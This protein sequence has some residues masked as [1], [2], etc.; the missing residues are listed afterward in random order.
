MDSLIWTE[1]YRPRSFKEFVGQKEIVK[2]VK[3]M[4]EQKNLNHLLLAGPAGCGKTSLILI[5]AIELYGPSWKD[6][7]FETNASQD[8]GINV[9][10]EDIKNFA[11]TKS[12][13]QVPFK[14]CILDEADALTKEA[15]HALRRTMEQYSQSCRFIL[16]VNYPSKIIEPIQ[17]RCVIFK[18]KP[19]KKD[20][21]FEIIKNVEQKEGLKIDEKTKNILYEISEGDARKIVNTLQSCSI[22][23]KSITEDLIFDTIPSAKPKEIKE[24]LEIAVKGNFLEA[25]NKMLDVMLNH[26]LS[27]LDIIKQIQKEIWNLSISDDKK[28]KL[29]EKCGEM[30][31]RMVEGADE[32]I[33]LEALLVNFIGK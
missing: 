21:S 19:I 30:E 2:K 27:G 24:V 15:Q 28:I 6:N 17:S 8:R 22:I 13:G 25:R 4:V 3:G 9:V 7:I 16:I 14:L 23:S 32:F 31:F 5:A 18:F 29:I 11:K 33:Q 1:K 26:S 10:R 12:L 20:E